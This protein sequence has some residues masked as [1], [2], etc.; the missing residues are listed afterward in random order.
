MSNSYPS[1][2]DE[3]VG[4]IIQDIVLRNAL[5][6]GG[7]A[8]SD[9][10][11]SKVI[12]RRP[13]LRDQIR[14]LIPQ[15]RRTVEEINQLTLAEQ[16]DLF[17]RTTTDVPKIS[18]KNEKLRILPALPDAQMEKVVTRFP[19]EP[20]GY[21]HIGHAKAAIIDEEYARLY[22]GKLI[23]RFDDTNPLKEK[24]EYYTSIIEGLDW[25][26]VKPDV[27][28]NTS[29]DIRLLLEYGKKLVSI[30]GAYVCSCSQTK[31]RESRVKGIPC[32]CRSDSAQSED[33]LRAFFNG[34]FEPNEAV[35]RFKGN[36]ADANTA[37]R[38]PTLFR[39]IDAHHPKLGNINRVWPTYDFAAPLEDSLDGVTHALRTKE[40]ELRNELY[41]AILDR[42]HI[43]RPIVL[44]FSRLQFEGMPVSKR[45]I[46]PLIKTGLV[47]G[48]ADPRLPTLEALKRRGFM[49]QA[50]RKFVLSLGL[51]LSETTP[52]FE[53]LEALN[54][55]II[56]PL[57]IRLFFVRNPTILM[58]RNAY[59]K[60][61][62]LNNHPSL[63]LGRRRVVVSD[64]F[65]I[66]HDDATSTRVGD[67]IRLMELYNVLITDAE[68]PVQ[69]SG[70]ETSSVNASVKKERGFIAE[71]TGDAINHNLRKVQWVA[72][73]DAMA[74]RVLVPK[75]LYIGEIYNRNSLE[76][77]QGYAE[78]HI[79]SL[80][81]GTLVQLVRFGFCS[82]DNHNT[83]IFTHR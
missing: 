11:I 3:D 43:R 33:R 49:A 64:I 39:I 38:D 25:L 46:V 34:S 65:Y 68:V 79:A 82:I 5:L 31:I 32:E 18:K 61:V 12:A 47:Q 66:D 75:R 83:A 13:D 35:I 58:V 74:Y 81:K 73:N 29:D 21:P 51:T 4:S 37:M 6:Y 7:K 14:F 27:V 80:N 8:R 42:L 55:K 63:D 2:T 60:E 15:I 9:N 30:G 44:E 59:S 62:I 53:S 50:I 19:P 45:K 16:K 72:K 20:N 41:Y 77:C 40:Y 22:N 28:K 1:S 24:I 56:D 26:G 54:R 48:W 36:I 71:R 70:L 67:E 69:L 57:S 76:S 17:A 52:P 10:V 23:L 78:S